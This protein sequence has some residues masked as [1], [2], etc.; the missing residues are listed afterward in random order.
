MSPF[1]IGQS[2]AQDQIRQELY[3]CFGTRPVA[4][5]YTEVNRG[6]REAQGVAGHGARGLDFENNPFF[7]RADPSFS[8]YAGDRREH[9]SVV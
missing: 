3:D 2:Q 9:R 1:K 8:E 6:M 5:M 4:S 7:R